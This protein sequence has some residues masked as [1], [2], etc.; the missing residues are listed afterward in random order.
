MREAPSPQLRIA[1]RVIVDP[2][3][4][5]VNP[6]TLLV[7]PTG[8]LEVDK[9]ARF[10]VNGNPIERFEMED[11]GSPRRYALFYDQAEADL[12]FYQ[13]L[14]EIP[15]DYLD[16]KPEF[17]DTEQVIIEEE[18][19]EYVYTKLSP[20]LSFSLEYLEGKAKAGARRPRLF[21]QLFYRVLNAEAAVDEYLWVEIEGGVVARLFVGLIIN[22]TQLT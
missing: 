19:R 22:K 14:Q 15:G 13:L 6:N 2:T 12:Y 8:T 5:L 11:P 4:T 16:H 7:P 20:T 9:V 18:G 17:I 10:T 1:Q 3:L 21:A